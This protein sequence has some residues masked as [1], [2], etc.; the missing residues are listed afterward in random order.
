MNFCSQCGTPV[1]PNDYFCSNCGFKLKI[2]LTPCSANQTTTSTSNIL[3]KA[4]NFLSS[5]QKRVINLGLNGKIILYPEQ[6]EFYID[7]YDCKLKGM[8]FSRL[9]QGKRIIKKNYKYS[10]LLNFSIKDTCL[11]IISGEQRFIKWAKQSYTFELGID[12][13]TD[14]LKNGSFYV[15]FGSFFSLGS[16]T[17]PEKYQ[18]SRK[19]LLKL[20]AAL[21]H[22]KTH[23]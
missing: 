17:P 16:N 8:F 12:I 14:D 18:E 4:L 22:I 6:K 23:K 21:E 1:Q 15:S 2:E 3:S 9:T 10:Q 11:S 20:V 7:L 19:N 5:S 13:I